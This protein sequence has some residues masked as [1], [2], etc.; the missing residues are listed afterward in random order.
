MEVIRGIR[1]EYY[2]VSY[3]LAQDP[4]SIPDRIFDL[5][6][7]I[8]K[9]MDIPLE[10][11][12]LE[13]YQE[14]AR[15]EKAVYRDDLKYWFLHFAR[16]RDTNLPS[17]AT[18]N[19]ETCPMEL[20]DDE[21]IG[22]DVTALYDDRLSVVCLQRNRYSLSPSGIEH[23]LN[24][25]WASAG[26]TIH[27]RAVRVP[28]TQELVSSAS[29]YRKL[30]VR[31]ADLKKTEFSSGKSPLKKVLEAFGEYDALCGEVTV[32]L[33]RSRDETLSPSTVRDS[34]DD[35]MA[36]REAVSRAEI[37][38]R[39]TDD[40]AVEVVDL[41][42]QIV[43]DLVYVTI[44]TKRSLTHNDVAFRVFEAYENKRAYLRD[45][46]LKERAEQ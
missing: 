37:K 3:R 16:L 4:S 38:M 9:A 17:K 15:L 23:Y 18:V 39:R 29:Q 33:G 5:R 45:I 27:L 7:W 28:D 34:I 19:T 10:R 21:Y 1:L 25:I 26:E 42:S 6:R 8:Q 46:L 11:R 30:T 13:Y 43:R 2:R 41:F 44:E 32:N 40:A 22:E 12:A 20:D 24:R 35:V 14:Q 31:F 36:N